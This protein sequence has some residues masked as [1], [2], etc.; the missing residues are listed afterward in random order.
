MITLL[1]K[2]IQQA[3]HKLNDLLKDL[4]IESSPVTESKVTHAQMEKKVLHKLLKEQKLQR[5]RK[6]FALENGL[7]LFAIAMFGVLAAFVAFLV[8]GYSTTSPTWEELGSDLAVM[9]LLFVMTTMS[10][11]LYVQHY[12]HKISTK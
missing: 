8:S 7:L 5:R 11:V 9:I 2:E 4:S 6:L 10:T 12:R 1:E 3:D